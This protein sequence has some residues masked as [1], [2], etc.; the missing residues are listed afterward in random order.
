MKLSVVTG[1]YNNDGSITMFCRDENFEKK[2]INITGFQ[3]YFYV[4][5]DDQNKSDSIN[6]LERE[7]SKIT[8][9]KGNQ[10]VKLVVR[11]PGDVGG[12]YGL[13]DK[14]SKHYEA[15]IPFIRRFM[16]DTEIFSGFE[17]EDDQNLYETHELKPVDFVQKP[18]FLIS[19]IEVF[20]ETRF[21][22]AEDDKSKIIVVCFYDSQTQMYL[23]IAIDPHGNKESE[24]T[25]AENHKV[26]IVKDERD[27]L[28][29]VK[30]VICYLDPDV[31]TG[32][33]I[34]FD[35]EFQEVR[36]GKHNL[37]F[38]LSRCNT[39]DLMTSYRRLYAKGSDRL[40]DVVTAENLQ[41]ENYEPFQN[42]FW[43]KRLKKAIY[44]NKSHVEA[45]VV[46]NKK[47]NLV[48]FFWELKTL[49]GLEDLQSAI[50]HGTVVETRFLR[51]YHNRWVLNS[52]PSQEEVEQRVA[53]YGDMLEGG[54]VFTPPVGIF[55]NV[56]NF[57]MTRYYPEM[58]ISMNLSPEPHGKELGLVP[59][60]TLEMIKKRI[61]YDNKMKLLTPGSAEYNDLKPRKQTVKDVIQTVVGY[62]GA[63]ESRVFDPEIFNKVT[64]M[65]QRGLL[66]LQDVCKRDNYKFI[67]G[68][69]DSSLFQLPL[70]EALTYSD[71]L[72]QELIKFGKQEGIDRKLEIKLDR[73]F[74][75]IIF[76]KKRGSE[77][78]VK[79][80]YA[81][82]IIFEDN[83]EVDYIMI[84]GFEYVRRDASK[85]TKE[86]QL[87]IFEL[88]LRKT[89][90]DVLGYLRQ[91]LND[92]RSGVYS[93]DDL[94]IPKTLHKIP[95]QYD[96]PQDYVRGSIYSNKW[97]D[98]GI[99][100][101]DVVKVLYV[102]QIEGLPYTDVISAFGYREI[103]QKITP[104][105]DKI[106]QKTIQ[107]KIEDLVA[108]IGIEWKE[109]EG[110]QSRMFQ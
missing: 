57:D 24:E 29:K 7:P 49:A 58:L 61:E 99:T 79:K 37:R 46:L 15:D 66:F 50:Y 35:K 74:K 92:I 48:N 27:L 56:G 90:E 94:A 6:I 3:P 95:T 23:S 59:E 85:V 9:F 86:M 20:S 98:M 30:E 19:D 14:F 64:T 75:K 40:A 55:E 45:C 67:Y 18:R 12:K 5:K 11:T 84:R 2:D 105:V 109:I 78:G 1:R 97:L 38:D 33:N 68:D 81:G 28:E 69:T 101:N 110:K 82:L 54:K 72:N 62:F 16:I 39:F 89:K 13:R 4:L 73:Y 26:I 65:G 106:I 107:D 43:E 31:Y 96:S 70:K 87:K 52:R 108:L 83:K 32:W 8:D 60:F 51:K 47:Y 22:D 80:R 91:K 25:F 21:P 36:F 77:E 42:E 71:K 102:K 104:D 10:L 93:Y 34:K 44:V 103:K 53:K 17:V 88:M 41:I 100:A 63:P 76:K